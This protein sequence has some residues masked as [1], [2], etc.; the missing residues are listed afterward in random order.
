[1]RFSGYCGSGLFDFLNDL[2]DLI[3]YETKCN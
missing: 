2:I 1:M 3:D